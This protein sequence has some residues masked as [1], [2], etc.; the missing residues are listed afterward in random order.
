MTNEELDK[1][2]QENLEL[3]GLLNVYR[4]RESVREKRLAK[5][6]TLLNKRNDVKK[7]LDIPIGDTQLKILEIVY[8]DW[9][10]FELSR[11]KKAIKILTEHI[12]SFPEFDHLAIAKEMEIWCLDKKEQP[13]MMRYLNFLRKAKEWKKGRISQ[14]DLEEYERRK[15]K[16]KLDK[17]L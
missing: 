17:Y 13:S 5:R 7:E 12:K 11:Q 4:K 9:F 10:D 3:K 8:P 15:T 1:I 2:K 6:R 14:E 16:E